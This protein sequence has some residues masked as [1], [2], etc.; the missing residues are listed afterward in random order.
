MQDQAE[1]SLIDP[2][3]ECTQPLLNLVLLGRATPYL[4]N[5]TVIMEDEETHMVRS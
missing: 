2:V 5:G 1:N 3:G 4:H